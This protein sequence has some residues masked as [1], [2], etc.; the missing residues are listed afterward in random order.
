MLNNIYKLD[1]D[2]IYHAVSWIDS[3]YVGST[4]SK[5]P[6]LLSLSDRFSYLEFG[7]LVIPGYLA[8]FLIA[9]LV[10]YYLLDVSLDYLGLGRVP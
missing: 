9:V 4:I 10:R 5:L 3:R 6:P 8:H 2:I 7:K 1:N